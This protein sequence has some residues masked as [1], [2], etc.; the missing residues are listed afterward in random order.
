MSDEHP[1]AVGDRVKTRK[2]AMFSGIVVVLYNSLKGV[3]H[4]VVEADHPWFDSTEH[5]Y[6]LA[7]L[8][9]DGRRQP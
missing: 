5:L 2:G 3:P 4:A 8:V 1:I 7:Q 6:P 9:Y